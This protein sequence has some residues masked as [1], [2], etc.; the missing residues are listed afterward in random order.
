MKMD[1]AV[2]AV[3]Q[4]LLLKGTRAHIKEVYLGPCQKFT[5][6]FFATILTRRLLF[7]QE[8]PF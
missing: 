8:C 5:M 6:E 1:I 3:Q 4:L 2:I 7:S